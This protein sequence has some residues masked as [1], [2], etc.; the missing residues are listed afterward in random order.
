MRIFKRYTL[1]FRYTACTFYY[2]CGR[3]PCWNTTHVS[4][5]SLHM[6]W[7]AYYDHHCVLPSSARH[8]QVKQAYRSNY[9]VAL[10]SPPPAKGCTE[11][12]LGGGWCEQ[13]MRSPMC[14][15]Y[16]CVCM[17]ACSITAVGDWKQKTN[18]TGIIMAQAQCVCVRSC[19]YYYCCCCFLFPYYYVC[20]CCH[21]QCCCSRACMGDVSDSLLGVAAQPRLLTSR[22]HT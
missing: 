3:S 16:T 10:P 5:F 1:Y 14:H 2:R 22:I 6:G 21:W 17:C 11:F 4:D 13:C 8:A 18:Q 15:I 12:P 20:C 19:S 9:P 7:S